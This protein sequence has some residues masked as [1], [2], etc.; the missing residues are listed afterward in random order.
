MARITVIAGTNGAGKSS[1][2]GVAL[3]EN[4]GAYFNPD[5]ETRTLLAANPGMAESDANSLAWTESIRQLKAAIERNHNYA[6]ETTLGGNTVTAMLLQA[7][8]AGHEVRVWY[9]G[10]DSPE[11]HLARIRSRVM[12]GGH[13][14]PE[15]KVRERYDTSRLN[16]IRLM[17]HATKVVVYDNSAEADPK[18]GKHPAPVKVLVLSKGTMMFP[19]TAAQMRNTPGWAKSLVAAANRLA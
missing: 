19:S 3:R 10:L 9:C 1:I 18:S 5:E 4:G 13:D 2:A 11:R 17:P 14:I 12:H 16:L 8:K 6:F 15:Q 7:A